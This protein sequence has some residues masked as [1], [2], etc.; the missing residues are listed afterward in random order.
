[1][2]KIAASKRKVKVSVA[3]S[4]DLAKRIDRMAKVTGKNRS[5]TVQG[6]IEAAINDQETT[7]SALSNPIIVNALVG[8]F[9]KPEVMREVMR[10]M[11]E[12]VSEEQLELFVKAMEV[13]VVVAQQPEKK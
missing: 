11:R 7:A 1:M 13:G 9:G 2:K 10:Q 6:L 3:M 5:Q 4:G 12:E 8:A